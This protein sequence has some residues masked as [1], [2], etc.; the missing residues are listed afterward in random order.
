MVVVPRLRGDA[1]E[2]VAITVRS[3]LVASVQPEIPLGSMV[4]EEPLIVATYAPAKLAPVSPFENVVLAP[5]VIG[6]L[7][8]LKQQVCWNL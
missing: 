3:T 5:M 2:A 4:S 1:P 8:R 6:R 7:M